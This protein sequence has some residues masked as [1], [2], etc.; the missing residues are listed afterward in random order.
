MG[1]GVE[2]ELEDGR[3]RVV[4]DGLVE[5][6]IDRAIQRR[7]IV[8][9]YLIAMPPV[10]IFGVVDRLSLLLPLH[11]RSPSLWAVILIRNQLFQEFI[12]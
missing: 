4:G 6:E 1:L 3:G 5:G 11:V 9:L 2:G 12:V 8:D 10:L 7:L